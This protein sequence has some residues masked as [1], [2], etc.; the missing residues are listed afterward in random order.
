[1]EGNDKEKITFKQSVS[2]R[3]CKDDLKTWNNTRES[4]GDIQEGDYLKSRTF[5]KESIFVFTNHCYQSR[6]L[7]SEGQIECS[8]AP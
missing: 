7:I 6:D 8:S 2:S 5:F 1:M 3:T 4:K